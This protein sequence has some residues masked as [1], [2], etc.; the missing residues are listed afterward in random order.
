MMVVIVVAAVLNRFLPSIPFINRLIL[1]PPGYAEPD[2][3]GLHLKPSLLSPVTFSGPISLGMIGMTS[4]SLRPTGKAMFGDKYV[5]VVSDGAYIDHGTKI[6]VIR[7]V[8]N[9]IIVRSA[10]E[11]TE[12]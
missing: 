3:E 6:E 12:A 2:G 11:A 5:D 8:G 1:T 10:D 7:L 4:S 9:R